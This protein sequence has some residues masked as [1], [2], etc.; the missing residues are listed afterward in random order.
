MS[1]V[2]RGVKHSKKNWGDSVN[3][4]IFQKLSGIEDTTFIP[5][6]ER[7]KNHQQDHYIMCGSIMRLTNSHS[8]IWGTG[9]ISNVDCIGM[10][11]WTDDKKHSNK[12]GSKPKQICAVRGPKTRDKLMAMGITECPEVYGDPVILFRFFYN[13]KNIVKKYKIGIIP[14]Y[15]D[16]HNIAIKQ[17]KNKHPNDITIIDICKGHKLLEFVDE[18]LECDMIFSSSLHGVIIG[19]VYGIPSY[20][21]KLS[22]KVTGGRF[23]FEDYYLSV[24]R[25]Y[26]E[27]SASDINPEILSPTKNKGNNYRDCKMPEYKISFDYEKYAKSC[28]F[29]DE[30]ICEE[31]IAFYTAGTILNGTILEIDKQL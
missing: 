2:I 19:D 7:K 14:N 16:F 5:F 13:P 28:P 3:L 23:K 25:E 6:Q 1:K 12:V 22:S 24:G 27:Y 20:H 4:F 21:V 11:T 29:I 15:I 30:K 18:V 17:L 9:F 10:N 31:L 26:K 8:I